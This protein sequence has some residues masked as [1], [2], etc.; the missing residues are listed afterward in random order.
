VAHPTDGVYCEPT[1]PDIGNTIGPSFFG[2][3]QTTPMSR[4]S[5]KPPD[6]L[7]GPAKAS[8]EKARA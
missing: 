7:N 4:P 3:L 2:R 6:F 1:S 5:L 8:R